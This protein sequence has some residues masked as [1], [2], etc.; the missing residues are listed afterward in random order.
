MERIIQLA[1][2]ALK[3]N[4]FEDLADKIIND[5]QTWKPLA[6]VIYDLVDKNKRI[7]MPELIKFMKTAK[8]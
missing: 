5:P 1:A 3:N 6:D 4:E 7:D 2:I 8:K